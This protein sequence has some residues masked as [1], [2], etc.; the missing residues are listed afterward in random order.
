LVR[1]SVIHAVAGITGDM[2]DSLVEAR[3]DRRRILGKLAAPTY[4]AILDEAALRRPFGGTEVMAQQI[5]WLI[6]RLSSR[7]ST[8]G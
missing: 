1:Q 3:L 2:Q 4:T 5:H 7:T 8:S 6:D